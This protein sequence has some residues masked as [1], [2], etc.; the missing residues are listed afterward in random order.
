MFENIKL[1]FD[2][3]LRSCGWYFTF[4]EDKYTHGFEV[5]NELTP[6]IQIKVIENM[7]TTMKRVHDTAMQIMT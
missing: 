2:D 5:K 1:I 7:L 3:N 4:R 6:D